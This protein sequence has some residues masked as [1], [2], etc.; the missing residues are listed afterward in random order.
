MATTTTN[1]TKVE[2]ITDVSTTSTTFIN[3]TGASLTF[4]PAYTDDIWMIFVSGVVRSTSTAEE[5]CELRLTVNTVEQD[6]WS[7]QNS[8]SAT[9]NGAGFLIFDRVTSTTALQTVALQFR[10]IAGTVTVSQVR[11]VAALVPQFADFQY[12]ESN[13]IVSTTGSNVNI[14]SLTFTPSSAGNYYIFGSAKAREFPGGSTSQVWFEGSDASLHPDAPAATRHS[15]ARDCWNP[16]T[17]AWRQNLPA[18]SQTFI[19][20]FTSSA[21]GV[22]SSQHRYRKFMV[23]REDAFDAANYNLSAAQTTTTAVTFQ[24]KNSLTT[25]APPLNFD[26]ISFQTARISGDTTSGTVQKAGELRIGGS[27]LVRT[28]HRITRDG[29]ATQGYHHTI[30]LCDVRTTG[31]AVAYANGFL[32]PDATT[33]IQCAESVIIVLR[34]KIPQYYQQVI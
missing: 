10:A 3:V 23:F 34:F 30:G 24:T 31:S 1:F 2:A 11:V 20:R 17:Y 29:S 27:A 21:S 5:S 13:G 26:Y 18:S 32:S 33:T 14:G 9:P 22:D 8:G 16:A 25:T 15:N 7:H 6:L 4:T 12:F 28:D 19:V